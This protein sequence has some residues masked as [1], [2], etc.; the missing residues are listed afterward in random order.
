MKACVTFSFL[1]ALTVYVASTPLY[2]HLTNG[3]VACYH[4]KLLLQLI[5][6][7][8]NIPFKAHSSLPRAHYIIARS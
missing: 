4:S 1:L 6:N 2:G 7:S 5:L 8:Q 3:K